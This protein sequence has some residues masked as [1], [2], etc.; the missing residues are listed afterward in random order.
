M[1]AVVPLRDKAKTLTHAD[2]ELEESRLNEIFENQPTRIRH[3][4]IRCCDAAVCRAL[5]I[6]K[7]MEGPIRKT[8]DRGLR[9]LN[10]IIGV[11]SDPGKCSLGRLDLLFVAVELEDV[12]GDIYMWKTNT[13]I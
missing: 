5:R 2:D 3:K 9:P 6:P 4:S 10:V 12:N 7:T 1:V 13:G 11:L 8:R